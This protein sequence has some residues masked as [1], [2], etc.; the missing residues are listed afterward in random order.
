[1]NFFSEP[2]NVME[3]SLEPHPLMSSLPKKSKPKRAQ[4]C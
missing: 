2:D 3:K 4:I 1:L